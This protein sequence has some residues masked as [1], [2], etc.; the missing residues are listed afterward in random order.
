MIPRCLKLTSLVVRGDLG[1]KANINFLRNGNE[2]Q[3]WRTPRAHVC[4]ALSEIGDILSENQ[5]KNKVLLGRGRLGFWIHAP[6]F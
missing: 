5:F 1:I 4:W 3:M 6:L 2:L